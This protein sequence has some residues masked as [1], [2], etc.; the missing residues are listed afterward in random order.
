MGAAGKFQGS[1]FVVLYFYCICFVP[2]TLT[3]VISII[4]SSIL[5]LFLKVVVNLVRHKQY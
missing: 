1:E 2:N 4:D 5:Y 3:A